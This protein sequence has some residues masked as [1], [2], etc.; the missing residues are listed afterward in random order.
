MQQSNPTLAWLVCVSGP[1]RGA[2]YRLRA[3]RNYIG[4]EGMQI[5]PEI[6]GINRDSAAVI[7]YDE[8][9]QIFTFGPCG[10]ETAVRLNGQTVTTAAVLAPYDL[11]TAGE[12]ELVFVPLCTDRFHWPEA[13]IPDAELEPE[14]EIPEA[15]EEPPKEWTLESALR[16]ALEDIEEIPEETP[17]PSPAPKLPTRS[18]R[19]SPKQDDDPFFPF[20]LAAAIVILLIGVVYYFGR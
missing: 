7:V 6:D 20:I 5:C 1:E 14:E 12:R 11:L 3:V 9:Q 15:D 17:V 4:S 8:A 2:E 13:P 19:P 16:E 10:I 18:P